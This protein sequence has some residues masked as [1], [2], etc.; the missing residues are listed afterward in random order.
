MRTTRI[1]TGVAGTTVDS[2]SLIAWLMHATADPT[3]SCVA[4]GLDEAGVCRVLNVDGGVHVLAPDGDGRYDS[5]PLGWA[6]PK[7]P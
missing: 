5:A 1:G 3:C 6:P 2:R 4:F 7:G